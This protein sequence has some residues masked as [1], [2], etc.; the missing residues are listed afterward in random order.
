M[1]AGASKE[2]HRVHHVTAQKHTALGSGKCLMSHKLWLTG[3]RKMVSVLAQKRQ[4]DE[5]FF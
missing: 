4:I 5:L 2:Q 1:P 3:V